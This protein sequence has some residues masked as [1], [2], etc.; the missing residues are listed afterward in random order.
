MK[1]KECFYAVLI[2]ALLFGFTI[3]ARLAAQHPPA[4][5]PPKDYSQTSW[6]P[7]VLSPYRQRPVAPVQLENSPRIEN[8]IH[9]GKLEISMANALALAIEN[10]LDISVER[11]IVPMAQTDVLRAESG[12]AARGFT[13]A[14][15]PLGLSS[16]AIGLGVSTAVQG[17]GVGNAGGIT[18]GGNAGYIVPP[19]GTFDPTINFVFSWD[20]TTAPLNTVVVSGIPAV[21]QY[22][23]LYSGSYTQMLPTGTSY[24]VSLNG[25]RSSSTQQNLLFDPSVATRMSMGFNQP[26]LNGL[27]LQPNERF[28]LVARNNE[29]ISGEIFRNQ[30]TQ[31]IVQVENAYWDMAQFQANVKVAE[32]ALATARA[33]YENTE[34]QEQ[35]GTQAQL[36]VA[37]TASQVAASERDLVIARTN[38]QMQ[39]VTLKNLLSKRTDP[40]LEA[41]AIVTTDPLPVP[42]ESDIPTLKSALADAYRNR[43]DLKIAKVNVQ[44]ELVSTKYTANDLLPTANVFAQYASA[45]LQGNCLV[46]RSASCG[47]IGLPAGTVVAQGV[48]SSLTQMIDGN[49]P[50]YSA[51][52]NLTLPIRNR[53]AQADNLRAQL[54]TQQTQITLQNLRN[55]VDLAVRQAMVGL[56]QGKAQVEAARK[57]TA[58]A[59]QTYDDE[60]KKFSVGMS[61]YYNVNLRQRDLTSAQYAEVQAL[62]AYAK[63][64]VA[65]DQARGK[66]LERNGISFDD[67][68]RGTITKAPVPPFNT[69]PTP[70]GK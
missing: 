18:G 44:N 54:E 69:A 60:E 49:F 29:E 65:M 52:L 42:R 64:L 66:M 51:G 15:I 68:L 10:N 61:T 34:K 35:A 56:V 20:R 28:L 6:F 12:Q 41:A 23:T 48:Q 53:S 57:A 58:F 31:T 36:D 3:P 26:L 33:L 47:G 59:Q 50:E 11:E 17:G 70:E 46:V 32:G 9:D 14:S 8:L 21:T 5:T 4:N 62:D 27:G 22:T 1:R 37:S 55:Q 63:A 39:E 45:G 2:G 13:G 40:N 24:F 43:S 16:G 38:L 67:A 30:V 19:V 7:S 25:Q